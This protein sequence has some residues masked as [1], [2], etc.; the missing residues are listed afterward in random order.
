[1][2]ATTQFALHREELSGG[3]LSAELRKSIIGALSTGLRTPALQ[4]GFVLDSAPATSSSSPRIE[5]II[6]RRRFQ[7]GRVYQRG[8]RWVGT[9]REYEANPD[10]GKR[11]RRTITFDETVKSWTAAK[12]ALKPYLD[13]Y[14]AK[15][16]ANT[17]PAAPQKSQ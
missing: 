15:A 6:S 12:K 16:E 8:K 5:K 13:D 10:T 4:T 3:P 1:M 14:N 11:A 9:Y 7:E 2:A 17:A